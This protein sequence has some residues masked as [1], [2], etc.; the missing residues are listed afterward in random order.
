MNQRSFCHAVGGQGHAWWFVITDVI[1]ALTDSVNP[2]GY[3]KDMRR[4]DKELGKLFKGG[5]QFA[6]PL[7]LEVETAGGPQKTLCWNAEGLL[8][9]IQSIPS[10]KAEPFKIWLAK[11]GYERLQEIENPELASRRMRELYRKKGY[12]EAKCLRARISKR[13][14]KRSSV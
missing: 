8:R 3:L 13:F 7:R 11:V 9:L 5:G 14:Q 4:R 6:T 2:A 1:E 12:S 10:Q